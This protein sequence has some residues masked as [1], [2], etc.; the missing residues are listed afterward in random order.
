MSA[1]TDTK[2][3][4]LKAKDFASDQDVRWCPGC[5][6]YYILKQTLTVLAELGIPHENQ[7]FISG[8]GCSSR[9]PYYVN[10]YGVHGIHGRAP[11]IA[12][13]VKAANPE[14]NLW[15][16]TG[17][18]DGLSIGGNH[19]IHIL[20]RNLDCNILL[21]NNAI[22]GLTKG[23]YSPTSPQGLKTKTSPQGSLEE[24]FNPISV[25][26]GAGATFVA[27]T[28]DKDSTHMRAVLHAATLH[29]G[30]SFIEIL[31]NCPI[32]YDGVWESITAKSARPDQTVSLHDGKPMIF[33]ANKEKAIQMQNGSP[34]V[35]PV[36]GTDP[37]SLYVHDLDNQNAGIAFNLS[38]MRPPALPL[39]IGIFRQVQRAEYTAQ[40]LG[41]EQ[42]KMQAVGKGTLH[43][44]LH[45]GEVITVT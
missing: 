45:K 37:D 43:K 16:I 24:P 41:Q 25:A 29:K 34:M 32:F 31:Q 20:R 8:I 10:S 12:F 4:K 18:G 14:L 35:V 1:P 13:G 23:Q 21:F 9:F 44:L 5:G 7:C 27:R 15:I 36:E 22:Y 11:A 19:L 26:L 40:M 42:T 28:H 6:D 17:D 30:T 2:K 33:G 3:T 38:Q 39:P